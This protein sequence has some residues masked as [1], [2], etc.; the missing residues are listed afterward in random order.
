VIA[1]NF[2]FPALEAELWRMMF[3]MTRIGAALLAAP[4]F[5]SAGVPV[6]L[7]VA[8]TGAI[9]VL[10]TAWTDVAAPPAL[11]S[12]Q[13]LLAVAGE[14]LI[15]LSMGFV[16]QLTFAAPTIAAEVISGTMGM[17]MATAVDPNTSA[18]ST[19]LGQYFSILLTL[20]FLAVDAHLH[21]VELIV[22]SYKVFPPGE[23]WLSTVQLQQIL[24]FGGDM[25]VT[26]I[27][28]ALPVTLLLLLV[29]VVTGVISRSAPSLNLFALGLP[30]SV[31]AGLIALV[32]AAPMLNEQ[33][34][35][36]AGQAIAD[37][38]TL[39]VAR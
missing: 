1:V 21:F 8:I 7:R 29:N 13:G 35:E 19:A 10:I 3:I 6:Q 32:I 25:L 33:L 34:L 37:A 39:L 28:L 18:G 36:L 31:F 15:G 23:A 30:A 4:I 2:G 9:A 12:I 20:A 26:A 5:S 11:L 16:I 17:S 22:Q 14:I 24:D 27:L 38:D